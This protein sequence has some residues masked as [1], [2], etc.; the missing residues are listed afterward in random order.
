[1]SEI[2]SNFDFRK[3]GRPL[4]YPWEHWCDGRIWKVKQGDDFQLKP[5]AFGNYLR[6]YA[7]RSQVHLEVQIDGD[8]VVFRFSSRPSVENP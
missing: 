8:Y 6:Q 7:K 2:L 1:V 5:L 4:I 3:V